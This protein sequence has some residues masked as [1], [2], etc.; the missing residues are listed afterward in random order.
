MG[1]NCLGPYLLTHLLE[2]ILVSTAA[3]EP[4]YSVRIVFVTALVHLA[5]LGEG[6]EFDTEGTPKVLI[7]PFDNYIQTK[8]GGQFLA[9]DVATRLDADGIMS[10]GVHPGLIRTELQR[11]D[12]PVP[13][14]F[15]VS[16]TFSDGE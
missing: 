4:T 14:F 15:F 13:Y 9:K 11:N 1:T 3:R 6:I 10:V 12:S 5:S 2:S 16:I 8:I 7:K